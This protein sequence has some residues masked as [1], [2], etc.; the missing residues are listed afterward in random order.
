MGMHLH[1]TNLLMSRCGV[2]YVHIKASIDI[3][4]E[5]LIII[6]YMESLY[7]SIIIM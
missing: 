3:I 1:V 7:P 5:G 6:Q 4:S 2:L